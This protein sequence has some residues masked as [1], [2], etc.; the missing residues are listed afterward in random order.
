MHNKYRTSVTMMFPVGLWG[1]TLT[2]NTSDNKELF[3]RTTIR[4]LVVYLVFLVDM[5]LCKYLI[6]PYTFFCLLFFV[7]VFV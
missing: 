1:T 7:A 3:V 5:C 6:L 4:E 2:E